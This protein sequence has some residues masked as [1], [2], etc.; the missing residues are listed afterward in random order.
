MIKPYLSIIVV[1]RNDNYC[2]GF[3]YRVQRFYDNLTYLLEKYKIPTEIIFVEW[4]PPKENKRVFQV[5]KLSK[6]RKYVS[7][8]FLEVNQKVHLKEGGTEK[9]P[10]LEA[11][12]KNVAI[13]RAKGKFIVCTNPDVIFNEELVNRIAR[14]DLKTDSFYRTAR[15]E[16]DKIIPTEIETSKLSEYCKKNYYSIFGMKYVWLKPR[17][18]KNFLLNFPKILIRAIWHFILRNFRPNKYEYMNVHGGA[19]GDFTLMSKEDW[20]KIRGYPEIN[21]QGSIDGYNVSAAYASGIKMVILEKK[22]RIYHQFHEYH[23]RKL[24]DFNKYRMEIS[25]WIKNKKNPLYNKNYW[26]LKGI[27]LREK[28]F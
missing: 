7:F 8:R 9:L 21:V 12:A 5:I 14:M 11:K 16:L 19:P 24:F 6:R 4:N 13:R 25:N 15:Y 1:G 10:L 3:M 27:K 23:G 17:L 18:S 28:V 22:Q 20:M 26:G 2:D